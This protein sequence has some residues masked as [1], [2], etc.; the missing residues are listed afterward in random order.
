MRAHALRQCE[1]GEGLTLIV[2]VVPQDWTELLYS[3]AIIFLNRVS[4][5]SKARVL[6]DSY[7][8]LLKYSRRASFRSVSLLSF[9]RAAAQK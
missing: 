9:I 8:R 5:A 2:V 7:L 1:F 6:S 4:P 3:T